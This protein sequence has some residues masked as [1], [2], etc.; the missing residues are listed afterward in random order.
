MQRMQR[1]ELRPSAC[2]ID[3]RR[4]VV[5]IEEERRPTDVAIDEMDEERRP[6]TTDLRPRPPPCDLA[7]SSHLRSSA[8]SL[9][10]IDAP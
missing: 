2:V 10:V 1:V 6:P 5:A 7:R 4:M 3:E 8:V 9:D